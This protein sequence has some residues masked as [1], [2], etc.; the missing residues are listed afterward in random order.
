ML[1]TDILNQDLN[2]KVSY[3]EYFAA[4]RY[5]LREEIFL[6][7]FNDKDKT[8]PGRNMAVALD[9]FNSALPTLRS[10]NQE[11]NGI[12]YVVNG[13]GQS[14]REV[15]QA[16]ACFIDFDDFSFDEQI[17]RINNF[18]LEPSIIV[19]TRKSLH[20]YWL[21]D[22]GDIKAFRMLQKRL[23]QYFGS[24]PSIKNESR[25]MRL[26]GFDHMKADPV[27][28]TLI[29]FDPG[30]RYSQQQLSEVLPALDP[31][32]VAPSGRP[33]P[34]G[35]GR[36]AGEMVP[37]GQRHYYVVRRIGEFLARL[38]DSASD[39]TI[40]SMIEADF[41]ENCEDAAGVNMDQFRAKYL[42]TITKLRA[43]HKEEEADPDFYRKAM[44]AWSEENPGKEFDADK[45]SWEEVKAAGLRAI[46]REESGERRPAKNQA[47]YDIHN[48]E[49]PDNNQNEPA[50]KYPVPN[51]ADQDPEE[52]PEP[53]PDNVAAYIDNIM[54]ED[55][56]KFPPPIMTGFDVFDREMKGLYAGLYVV[57]AISSLGK[58]TFIHQMADNIAASGED[59]IFF[60]LEMSRLEMVSKSI[61]RITAQTDPARAV[62]C[63]K[64]RRGDNS[65][66]VQKA[67]ALYKEKVGSR[68][69]IIE[70]KFDYNIIQIR[71][72]VDRYI[73]RTGAQP[74]V[75]V[76]YL[77]VITPIMEN[78]RVP[79]TRTATDKTTKGLKDLSRDFGVPV[80]V[81][82]SLNRANYLQPVNFESLKESGG[83]EYTADVVLGLNLRCLEEDIFDK[84]GHV[85]EKRAIINKAK[86]ENPRR[87]TLSC[88]KN[89]YG[90]ATFEAPFLYYPSNDLFIE[91]TGKAAKK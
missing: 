45:Q 3:F 8:I 81:I 72:Y 89:R 68:L 54:A 62:S 29:K 82:C 74:V 24:D 12:F 39:Q 30:I 1:T 83:I 75:I 49:L 91:D 51:G 18:A 46:D 11:N 4:F 76:D 60:S 50:L 86:A 88:L 70:G 32:R 43:R 33:M 90:K 67:T 26:Y 79:D 87:I 36:A 53:R 58:T 13:G 27:R 2:D 25:V 28:V 66:S 80:I 65:E 71:Q 57:A 48:L 34:A 44:K 19:K 6:R 73:K 22:Q 56:K 42:Q 61:A 31:A 16:R 41:Y 85:K 59:V 23:I 10:R 69:S 64:I 15:K 47:A 63:M 38:K 37:K 5:G 78:G 17:R 84:E 55:I 35:S 52:F 20:C 40:L 21:L 77:Q 14:D 9:N 7:C